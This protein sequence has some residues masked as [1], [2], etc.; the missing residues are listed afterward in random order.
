MPLDAPSVAWRLRESVVRFR[1]AG[2]RRWNKNP[3]LCNVCFRDLPGLGVE[4]DVAIMFADLRGSTSLGEQIEPAA[5]AELLN[6]FYRVAIEVLAPHRAVIDKMIG[7][8]VMAFFVA[9]GSDNYKMSAVKAASELMRCFPEVM[10]EEEVPRL[11]IGLNAGLA[12]EGK[13]GGPPRVFRQ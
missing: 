8:E 4:V 9:F 11:G 3:T 1:V 6:R 7:D 5:F 13:V 2:W 12:F 10:P